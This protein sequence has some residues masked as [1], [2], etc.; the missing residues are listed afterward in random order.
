[1]S[2]DD[3]PKG[4]A[5]IRCHIGN[6]GVHR[7]YFVVQQKLV[8]ATKKSLKGLVNSIDCIQAM[9]LAYL[10]EVTESSN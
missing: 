3:I 5:S 4:L 9:K 6:I 1:V 8:D 2:Y 7:K 10:R